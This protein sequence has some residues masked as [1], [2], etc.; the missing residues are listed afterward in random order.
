MHVLGFEVGRGE[1][2]E[3]VFKQ[4]DPWTGGVRVG[5]DVV[6]HE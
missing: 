2:V 4:L 5:V 6:C 3:G 1:I